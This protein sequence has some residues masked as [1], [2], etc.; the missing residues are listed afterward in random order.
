MPAAAKP[1]FVELVLSCGSWQEAQRIADLLIGKELTRSIEFME[2]EVAEAGKHVKLI[3]SV[4]RKDLK[5]LKSETAEV[6]L[7]Q[8]G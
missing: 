7:L 4:A 6:Q 1:D 2:V 3:L 8:T 5:K